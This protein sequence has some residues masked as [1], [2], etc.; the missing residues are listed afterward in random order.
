[1]FTSAD[2]SSTHKDPLI[3]KLRQICE[4]IG[5]S[6]EQEAREILDGEHDQYNFVA[7]EFYGTTEYRTGDSDSDI[8]SYNYTRD[9]EESDATHYTHAF[10]PK[11]EMI[12]SRESFHPS[13]M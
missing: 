8:V 12:I 7:D 9:S 10:D 13:G 11:Y 2:L 5:L 4:D 6:Y 1:M 3:P